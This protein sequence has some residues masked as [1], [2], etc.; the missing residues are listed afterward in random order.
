MS[1]VS[2]EES[3]LNRLAAQSDAIGQLAKDSGGFSAVIAAFASEDANAFRW[4]L[5]RIGLLPRCELICEWVETKMCGLRC[6]EVCGPIDTKADVPNLQQFA[7]A[8][9]Q[10]GSNEKLLRRVI[11][12]V[13]CGDAEAYQAS[14]SE[15]NL[16]PFCHL[17]CRYVCSSIYHR[18]CEVVCTPEPVYVS[19]AAAD[20]RSS[21]KVLA[22]LIENEKGI[23]A[24]GSAAESLNCE[25]LQ[26]S[27]NEAGVAPGCEIIC[28]L[29]CIRHCVKV[30]RE[31]CQRPVTVLT[32]AR[33]VEEAR[34]FALASQPLAN[35]P[36]VLG[37]LLVAVQ[38]SNAEAYGAV[39]ARIGLEPYCHQ[40]CAWVCSETCSELCRCVCPNTAFD[41][42]WTN[43]GNFDIYSDIDVTGKTNKSLPIS[44][45]TYGGGP[46]FAFYE[47][48]ALTGFCPS[49]SPISSGTQMMYRFLYASASTTLASAISAFA[50]SINV[51]SSAGVPPTPFDVS[52]CIGG[53]SGETMTVTGVAGTTW[54]VV[55]GEDGTTAIS[56]PA[57]TT[58][59]INPIP[60]TN[61]LICP[62]QIGSRSISWPKDLAGIAGTTSVPTNERIMLQSAPTPV[63]PAPPLSGATWTSPVHYVSPDPVTGW[64]EV[65]LDAVG[66]GYTTLL[67]F[68]TTQPGVAP[69]TPAVV[70]AIGTPGC[71]PAGSPVPAADVKGGTDLAIIFQA[72]RVGTTAIDFSNSLC[73]IHINNWVEINN[74]WFLEFGTDCCTPIDGALTVEFTVDHEE[75]D[76]GQWSLVISSCSPSAPG[77]ITP[78]VSGP[79]VTLNPRGGYG[80]IPEVTT[81]WSYC[82]Y[83]VTLTTRPGLT[84]G[85]VDR[86]AAP[87]SLP[88]CICGGPPTT[89]T[90]ARKR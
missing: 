59:W 17:I 26:T 56:A 6:V 9:V 42:L 58:L 83:T 18:I 88:F 24:I 85:I 76:A 49:T 16:E 7:R 61:N 10:L 50:T 64:I 40:V 34:E 43:V 30:C 73:R 82:S 71:S 20:I 68:D 11:D 23:S 90:S 33:A 44:S 36:R 39:I 87:L 65:D 14:I 41:P 22:A 72:T 77:D 46:N 74:L 3:I 25:K 66:G 78:T 19:D 54:T 75:M 35:Q 15:L 21:A 69:A 84:T 55:R 63:D 1:N 12:A 8:I 51:A 60:I 57:G 27:I 89:S 29:I 13:S 62:I 67:C 70:G 32:G 52:L 5:D 81:S 47:Q 2:A 31:L 28:R 86:L 48:L 53:E 4:V 38:E 80:N 37:D 45:L 79:T